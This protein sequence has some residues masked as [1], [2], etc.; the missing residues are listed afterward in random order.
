M[1]A[2][3][4]P[5]PSP[6]DASSAQEMALRDAVD[7]FFRPGGGLER[8]CANEPFP[9][10]HRPQQHQM[11]IAV[12][13]AIEQGRPLVVEAGTGVGKSFAYLVPVLLA[14]SRTGNKAIVST[15]TIS[16]QEQLMHKDIPFLQAHLGVAFKAVLAK[17]RN[18]YLCKRRL[19]AARRMGGELFPS[20]QAKEL[21]R[22]ERWVARTQDGSLQDLSPQP[23]PDVWASVCAEEGICTTQGAG[24]HGDCFLT[25]ARRAMLEAD[26]LVVNHHLFF[27]EL[28]LRR[29]GRGFFPPY[30]WVIL[31]EAHE[32]ED[33]ATEH[34]GLRLSEYV[35]EH[36]L[37]RLYVPETNKGLLYTLRKGKA[38]H[39]VSRLRDELAAFFRTVEQEVA[40]DE[41][42]PQRVLPQPL[43]IDPV[44]PHRIGALAET[45]RECADQVKDTDLKAEFLAAHRKGVALRENLDA[46]LN[47]DLPEHVYW[48]EQEG[49][50]KRKQTVLYSAPIEVA[51]TLQQLLFDRIPS[52]V[53]TSATL[54][55]DDSLDYFKARTGAGESAGL[56][57]GSSFDFTR[58]MRVYIPKT[59]PDPNQTEAFVAAASRAIRHFV[60]QSRGRAFVLFT[61]ARMLGR[62]ADEVQAALR[63]KGFSLLVQG[64]GQSRHRMLEQFQSDPQCVLFG[65]NSFWMGVDVRGEALSNVIITRL[66][67]AVPDQPITQARMERIR[68]RGGDPF[69]DYALPVAILRFR[70]GVGRLIRTATDEGMVVILDTRILT[71]WYGR[72]FLRALPESPV[73]VL[74]A[75]PEPD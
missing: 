30:E 52:V 16:L 56:Q 25:C 47:Q 73:E 44:L 55:V 13:E 70:Q 46:Y 37:R 72:Y 26:V 2:M 39:L 69:R 23:S 41:E 48:V 49:K 11:A 31:D 6:P 57:V 63:G 9:Y 19:E 24:R 66:P 1:C 34:M 42:S 71:K 22:I 61:S 27:S 10:E 4:A 35:F 67:F 20:E 38:A 43:A 54:A 3:I 74:E 12:A 28:A 8:A 14:A 40:L 33:V 15:H 60:H 53:M 51:P 21:Q 32:I 50:R 65:L 64:R 62:V 17:G 18:N 58:Q 7:A 36:W 59:M 5:R 75:I 45:V 68:E 29:T